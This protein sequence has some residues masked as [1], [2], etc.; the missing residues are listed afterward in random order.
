MLLKLVLLVVGI[1]LIYVIFRGYGKSL[2]KPQPEVAEE[3]MVRCAHC[4][5][6]QPK[7]ESIL[8]EGKFYCSQEHLR[9]HQEKK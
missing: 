7:S 5:V 8:S 2:Q 3:D 6:H 1:W 4:G 9:L